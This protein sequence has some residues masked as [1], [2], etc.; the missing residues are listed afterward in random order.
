MTVLFT[1]KSAKN[2]QC[3]RR[4]RTYLRVSYAS[5]TRIRTKHADPR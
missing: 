4:E 2:E 5:F 3:K 1:F